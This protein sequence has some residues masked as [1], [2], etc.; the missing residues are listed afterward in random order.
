MQ[1]PQPP[2][3]SAIVGRIPPRVYVAKW[4]PDD[5]DLPGAPGG[6]L[7]G[8]FDPGDGDFKKGKM[9]PAVVLLLILAAAA[10]IGGITLF[11]SGQEGMSLTAEKVE[12]IKASTLVLPQEQQLTEYRRWLA[13]SKSDLLVEEAL[14][15]L[16]WAQD[17]ATLE[18][19]LA[20]LGASQQK[21]RAQAALAIAEYG[22]AAAPRARGP[23]LAALAEAKPESRPQIAWAL[24]EIGEASAFEEIVRLYRAGHLSSVRR[25]DGSIAFDPYKIA[26]LVSLDK[27]AVLHTDE[28]PA[29]RQ[30]VATVL[31]QSPSPKWAD[32]LIALVKDPDRSVAVQAAP[33]LGAL[34]DPRSIGPLLEQLGASSAEQRKA[35]LEALRDGLGTRGLLLALD[36]IHEEDATRRWGRTRQ[37]FTM[38]RELADPKGADALAA[39]LQRRGTHVH[40]QVEAALALAEVGDLRAVPTLAAR[41]ELDPQEIYTGQTDY[42]RSLRKTSTERIVAARMVSDLAWLHP[43]SLSQIRELAEGP[44]LSWSA[45]G[46]APHANAMRALVA[47][48]STKGIARVRGWANPRGKL[49][50]E[51]A[52]PPLPQKWIIAQTGLRYAGLARDKRSWPVLL[53]ALK[54]RPEKVDASMASLQGGGLTLLGM[55]LRGLGYGAAQGLSE[56]GDPKAFEPLLDYIEDPR[57]N[58]Q[59]RLAACRALAWVASE[60]GVAAIV[61]TIRSY[62]GRTAED[63]TRQS[64]LLQTLATRSMPGSQ[65]LLLSLMSA[66]QDVSVRRAAARAL[67]RA[68]FGE[69]VAGPLFERLQDERL[70]SDA[71]LA[72]LLGGSA[73]AAARAV[74]GLAGKPPSVRDELQELWFRSFGFWSHADLESGYLFRLVRNAEAASRVAVDG[75]PQNWV[76]EQLRRQ[77]DH[78]QFDSGPH[79][80]TRVVLRYRLL[81]FA[82]GSEPAERNAA[83]RC[84][85]FMKERGVLLALRQEPGELGR[86]AAESLHRLRFPLLAANA[87]SFSSER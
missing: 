8:G 42:E 59:S 47:L 71:A 68:G 75:V 21:L 50:A 63:R 19:I 38:V 27:L 39:Y 79:S 69:E 56:W 18:P 45:K 31:S 70:V 54:R 85:S 52:Q 23:L 41:I 30:L 3:P 60:D 51:G 86:L 16:A 6:G 35:F 34:G 44:L 29:V 57:E 26:R 13:E 15:R 46:L 55:T 80:F 24:V 82:L 53:R 87:K 58:E 66:D 72:L 74:A 17:E 62:D 73:E 81:Q 65:P 40:W 76:G 37:V 32:A 49:P 7:P 28:S 84:L 5:P 20:T 64:C 77:F 43:D 78:L 4:P 67:G 61:D 33:G 48:R 36:A 25:L 22:T 11:R 1:E 12:R 83:L 9:R 10:V 2:S 14:K